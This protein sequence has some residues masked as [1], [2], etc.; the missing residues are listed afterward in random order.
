MQGG[1]VQMKGCTSHSLGNMYLIRAVNQ[2]VQQSKSLQGWT[3]L[4]DG[5]QLQIGVGEREGWRVKWEDSERGGKGE[6]SV[7]CREVGVRVRWD[8]TGAKKTER[9]SN[10]PERWG[11]DQRR[12]SLTLCGGISPQNRSWALVL[13]WRTA[14]SFKLLS[15]Q[16]LLGGLCTCTKH[17]LD[18]LH[19]FRGTMWL[20]HK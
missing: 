8:W 19:E 12:W 7:W 3:E 1:G 5:E 4:A 10:K 20:G 11:I 14:S 9:K 18:E 15:K 17:E 2:R 6:K 13:T 16:R